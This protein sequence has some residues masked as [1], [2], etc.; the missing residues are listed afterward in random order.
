MG[1][2]FENLK[3]ILFDIGKGDHAWTRNTRVDAY[4]PRV[5]TPPG[6]V[7]TCKIIIQATFGKKV[8]DHVMILRGHAWDRKFRDMALTLIMNRC[9]AHRGPLSTSRIMDRP[10]ASTQ[11]GRNQSEHKS[12]CQSQLC[13][14]CRL[15]F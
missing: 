14:E 6:H 4:H 9:S 8:G 7:D 5:T 13:K 12:R 15:C 11:L 1:A 3:T 2:I 10:A